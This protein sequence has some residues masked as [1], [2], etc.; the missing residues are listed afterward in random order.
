MKN[1]PLWTVEVRVVSP[2]SPHF[3]D[4]VV[5]IPWKIA[6]IAHEGV[7]DTFYLPAIVES[8]RKARL[9]KK[10]FESMSSVSEMVSEFRVVKFH[11]W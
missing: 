10:E 11:G 3:F 5:V 6:E 8:R 2:A 4:P 1:H 7:I 9:L